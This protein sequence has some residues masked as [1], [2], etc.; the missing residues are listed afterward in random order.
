MSESEAVESSSDDK[1]H[2][3]DE[4]DSGLA[5]MSSASCMSTKRRKMNSFGEVHWR[6]R[7]QWTQDKVRLKVYMLRS[8]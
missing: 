6:K 7:I 3:E 1:E 8:Y 4:S 2:S 5:S